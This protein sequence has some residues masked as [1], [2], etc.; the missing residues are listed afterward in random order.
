MIHYSVQDA[1]ISSCAHECL[2]VISGIRDGCCSETISK[3][4]LFPH[5]LAT[6]L[7]TE[8]DSIPPDTEPVLL[9]DVS[10]EREK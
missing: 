1:E 6:R 9:E 8:A 5:Y 3:H 7:V 10:L 4:T 2:V